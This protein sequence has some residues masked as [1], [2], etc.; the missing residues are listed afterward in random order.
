MS[1]LDHYWALLNSK[2]PN[3]VDGPI[4]ILVVHE[5]A[6]FGAFLPFWLADYIPSLQKYKIQKVLLFL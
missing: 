1:G 2:F 4:G 6:Y 3:A 5:V